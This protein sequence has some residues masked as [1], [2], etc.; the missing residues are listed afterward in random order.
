MILDI[1]RGVFLRLRHHEILVVLAL[2]G[3]DAIGHAVRSNS[4]RS[5]S[6]SNSRSRNQLRTHD[7]LGPSGLAV[8]PVMEPGGSGKELVGKGY[9]QVFEIF[10]KSFT[11]FYGL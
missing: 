1:I 11:N 5:R 10:E 4:R 8:N 7:K 6:R 3:N 9:L 2:V